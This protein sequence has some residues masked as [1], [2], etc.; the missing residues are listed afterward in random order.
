[1]PSEFE[2]REAKTEHE[3]TSDTAFGIRMIRCDQIVRRNHNF[4]LTICYALYLLN[5][6]GPSYGA[7]CTAQ[8]I[9]NIRHFLRLNSRPGAKFC[10]VVLLVH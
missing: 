10:N 4:W 3:V 7:R 6:P 9:G 2:R 1:M 8:E 5:T